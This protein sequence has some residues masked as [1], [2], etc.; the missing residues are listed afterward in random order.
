M[1][2][3]P[4]PLCK[5][6]QSSG[7]S[8]LELV[9][10]M[11]LFALVAVMGVQ[12]LTGTLRMRDRLQI[13]SDDTADLS[14]ALA[15]LRADMDSIVPIVFTA[16]GARAV[17]A[18]QVTP[19]QMAFSIGGQ[20]DMAP[21]AGLGLHRVV[22]RVDSRA[23]AL[24]RQIWPVLSPAEDTALA[25]EVT[26]LDGVS[27]LSVRSLWPTAGWVRGALNPTPVAHSGPAQD[28]DRGPITNESYS[29][30]LPAAFEVTID[31]DHFGR[32]VLLESLK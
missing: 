10:A 8:L 15:L 12:L 19:D 32:I 31:T 20:F 3:E 29:D 7:L 30:Q 5:N 13:T 24:T 11:A 22:W 17:S 26:V 4:K 2:I 27:A 23:G 6:S 16:P 21:V 9:V 18:L 25:P 14:F 28:G 1:S